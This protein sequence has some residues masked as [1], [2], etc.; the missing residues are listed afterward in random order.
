MNAEGLD[1]WTVI[2]TVAIA[3]LVLG[4]VWWFRKPQAKPIERD[5]IC[6]ISGPPGAGKFT[7]AVKLG[8]KLGIPVLSTGGTLRWAVVNKT[9]HGL[10][11]QAAIDAA[12]LGQDTRDPASPRSVRQ[13]I[14][15][16]TVLGALRERIEQEDCSKGCIIYGFPRTA[17]Q[18]RVLEQTLRATHVLSLEVPDSSL[19][20]RINGRW[21]H[22]ASG[23]SYHDTYKPAKPKSLRAGMVGDATNMK[24]DVTGDTL[25]RRDGDNSRELGVRIKAFRKQTEPL[26]A[27]T[28]AGIVRKI[29]GSQSI[30]HVW[31]QVLSTFTS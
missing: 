15:L 25:I 1:T 6:I 28:Y 7:Q 5:T 26:I 30:D 21:M 29:D 20:E 23:R 3:N 13:D 24:D 10:Q 8:D 31:A 4:T 27:A 22:K 17:V 9:V 19:S 12:E 16:A 11:A 14:K 2:V 18:A